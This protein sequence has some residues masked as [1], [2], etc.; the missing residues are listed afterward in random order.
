MKYDVAIIGGGPAGLTAGIYASR[1]GLKTVLFEKMT[2]GGQSSYTNEIENFPGF[3]TIS[4]FE[5]ASKMH[6][7]AKKC[8]VEFLMQEVVSISAENEEKIIKTKKL[9]YIAKVIIIATGASPRFLELENEQ[10]FIGA[11]VSYCATC[12]G[13]FFKN[14]V[15][16][17]VGGGNTALGDALYLANFASTVNLIHRRDEFRGNKILAEKVKN[18]SKIKIFY[19]NTISKIQ[20]SEKLESLEIK[21]TKTN[22]LE[23]I[24][25][26]GLFVAVGQKP[27]NALLSGIDQDEKGYVITNEKM[28]TNIKGIFVVGDVRKKELRQIVT[29]CADGAIAGENAGIYI[30]SK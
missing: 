10:K 24:N 17:V 23:T 12:D 4:G 18:N 15:V 26:D 5:L 20:G 9:E 11:G 25:T 27:I 13:A 3:G 29:A 8:G 7:Q 16:S 14:K 22:D 30:N 28:E 1:A 6:E 19:D 21:N 2:F